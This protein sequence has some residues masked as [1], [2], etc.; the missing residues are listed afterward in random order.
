MADVFILAGGVFVSCSMSCVC[1]FGFDY[2]GERAM[3][4][5]YIY[6]WM[7]NDECMVY[8]LAKQMNR[9]LNRTLFVFVTSQ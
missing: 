9:T 4:L 3:L 8:C 7:Q 1:G 5:L 2:E 6:M